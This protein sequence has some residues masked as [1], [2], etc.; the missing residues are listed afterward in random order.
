MKG[1]R[2]LPPSHLRLLI[3]PLL[4]LLTLLFL[5]L[6]L[7][8]LPP[9]AAEAVQTAEA[10][11]GEGHGLSDAAHPRRPAGG[12]EGGEGGEEEEEVC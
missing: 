9:S 6:L 11:T 7:F 5:H 1:R 4:H 2:A 10:G 3:P 12:R 8:L